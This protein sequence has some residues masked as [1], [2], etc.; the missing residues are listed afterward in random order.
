MSPPNNTKQEHCT[1]IW[2]QQPCQG[3]D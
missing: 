2:C 1:D 3:Q